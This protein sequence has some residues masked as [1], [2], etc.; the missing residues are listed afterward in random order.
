MRPRRGRSRA[1]VVETRERIIGATLDAL[2][3]KGYAGTT[4]R[5][6]AAS[7]RVPV[8]LIFYHFG[9]LDSLLLAVL[10][11][12][13]ATRLPR[14]EHALATVRD[15]TG[16]MRIMG[17]LYAED[18]ASGHAVAVRELVS[19]GGLSAR[20]G[21]E[22]A[23]RMEPWFALAEAVA[24]RVLDGS[25]VLRLIPARDLAVTAVSLYIGLDIVSRLAGTSTSAATLVAAGERMAPLLGVL[26]PKPRPSSPRPR[27]ISLN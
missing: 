22:I 23:A 19:N 10:D 7:A 11:H 13:S 6:I 8:G 4:A 5:V 25:P 15:P 14:W 17:E 21:A 1:S 16:L 24:T 18:M 27:R 2:T 12:T 26:T 3:H 9:T 20:L